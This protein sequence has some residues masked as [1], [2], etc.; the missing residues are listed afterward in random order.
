[1]NAKHVL[2]GIE[3]KDGDVSTNIDLEMAANTQKSQ[4]HNNNNYEVCVDS[5]DIAKMRINSAQ[6]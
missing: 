6:H 2:E 4:E 1:M 3:G 5:N